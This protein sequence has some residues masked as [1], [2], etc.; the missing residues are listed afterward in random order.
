MTNGVYSGEGYALEVIIASLVLAASWMSFH[1]LKRNRKS[2]FDDNIHQ[3]PPCLPAF[4]IVGSLPFI[5]LEP[6]EVFRYFTKLT[7]KYGNVF[8][9]Y[10]GT[11]YGGEN[12]PS[13]SRVTIQKGTKY[14]I[15]M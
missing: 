2:R 4:P 10:L 15:E 5:T 14:L 3:L 9:L 6:N 7:E 12:S 8:S 11:R 1:F 13:L